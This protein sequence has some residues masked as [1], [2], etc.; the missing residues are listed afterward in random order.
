MTIAKISLYCILNK[1]K[2]N[3]NSFYCI[4]KEIQTFKAYS[5][6]SY[7][8]CIIIAGSNIKISK[9]HSLLNKLLSYPSL[10]FSLVTATCAS[11]TFLNSRVFSVLGQSTSQILN[12]TNDH[13]CRIQFRFFSGLKMVFSKLSQLDMTACIKNCVC[14]NFNL[15]YFMSSIIESLYKSFSFIDQGVIQKKHGRI[16]FSKG[17]KT[18]F[19]SM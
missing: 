7:K 4:L 12:V 6:E 13:S 16:G 1:Q 2:Y 8:Y 18:N 5:T 11:F 9:T 14:N 17:K 3:M 15:R 19:K 10:P